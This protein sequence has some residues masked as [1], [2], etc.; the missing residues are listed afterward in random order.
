MYC[1][2]QKELDAIVGGRELVHFG[3]VN[4]FTMKPECYLLL[5]CAADVVDL[6]RIMLQK[7]LKRM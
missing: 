2:P 6:S 5:Y 7:C 4:L 1:G 3:V